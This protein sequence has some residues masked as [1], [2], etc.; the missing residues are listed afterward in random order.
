MGGDTAKKW[1]NRIVEQRSMPLA[2]LSAHSN[3]FRRHP[4]RQSAALSQVLDEV[5]LVQGCVLN[6]RSEAQGWPA[7]DVPTLVDG[8]LRVELARKRKEVVLPVTIVDLSP[9]EE[10]LV[11]ATLDPLGALAETDADVL[12]GLIG[13]LPDFTADLGALLS[14]LAAG[15][16]VFNADEVEPPG[17]ADGDRSP[18]Q[19]MTFTLHDSQAETVKEALAKAKG[20]GATD[21]DNENSNGNALA[22]IAEA[23]IG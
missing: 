4:A 20:A 19:Q 2:D 22:M 14:D 12:A 15:G 10:R 1:R 16:G 18:F 7:G 21:A 8:H 6:L 9:D 13:E 3:N 17:L 23:F 11:L 5:G